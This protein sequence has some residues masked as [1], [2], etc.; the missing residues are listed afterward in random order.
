MFIAITEFNIDENDNSTY[1]S[2]TSMDAMYSPDKTLK[3]GRNSTYKSGQWFQVRDKK[4][5]VE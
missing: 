5:R 3:F 1:F 4:T 2:V